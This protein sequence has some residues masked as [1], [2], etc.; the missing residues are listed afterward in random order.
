MNGLTIFLF[1]FLFICIAL[2]VI[3]NRDS[4]YQKRD[5][6]ERLL[7]DIDDLETR[8]THASFRIGELE[9]IT[10]HLEQ[11]KYTPE[12]WAMKMCAKE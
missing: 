9:K 12:E 11:H 10:R 2:I 7:R 5:L 8:L 4:Y 6:K 3:R 1:V